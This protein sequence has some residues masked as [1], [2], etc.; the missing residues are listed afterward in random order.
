M[1][2][3]NK[4]YVITIS[5]GD[6]RKGSGGT[7]KVILAHKELFLENNISMIHIYAC[8]KIGVRIRIK[9]KD[10][11]EVINDDKY[12]GI[13]TTS[14]L[15]RNVY[16]LSK[17]GYILSDVFIHHF[18]NINLDEM[19]KLLNYIKVP[20]KFY[21]HDYMSVCPKGGLVDT[22]GYFCGCSE[23]NS[24]KCSKCNY[25]T[26]DNQERLNEIKKFFKYFKKRLTFIAPS[27]TAKEVWVNTYSNYVN[28]VKTIYHQKLQG[29]YKENVKEIKDGEPIK[30]AFV[31]YQRPLKGA[32]IW[33]DAIIRL[34]NLGVNERFYQFGRTEELYDFVQQIEVDVSKNINDMVE[35]LRE[36]NIDVAVLWS[37]WP[38]TYS[39]TYYEAYASNCFVLTSKKSGNIAVQTNNNGNGIVTENEYQ[40][41]EELL[42][43]NNL[44]RKINYWRKN[45]KKG[46]ETIC[47]NDEIL[48][49][50]TKS[51]MRFEV[52]KKIKV[53]E[54]V[55]VLHYRILR[56]IYRILKGK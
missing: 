38:E 30:I 45:G 48:K 21:L 47:E 12:C 33:N 41:F 19:T 2:L 14:Q 51:L 10:L 24:D 18:N 4:R 53:T 3:K 20:I 40:L 9:R 26:E 35:K 7:D 6:Y 28:Q 49:L 55:V 43:E 34:H 37:L 25:Y 27:P 23:P 22:N 52:K 56:E 54:L 42:D 32:K 15:C 11:W 31:G 44:R 36:N 50:L 13:Y 39:Y 1:K 8:N 29:I 5:Y 16:D 46:P 17:K